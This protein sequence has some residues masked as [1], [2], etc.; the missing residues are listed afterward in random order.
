MVAIFVI[1]LYHELQ[2]VFIYRNKC[3]SEFFCLFSF[4]DLPQLCTNTCTES[5]DFEL[6]DIC[7]ALPCEC[8]HVM[9]CNKQ[10]QGEQVPCT[11][12]VKQ[13]VIHNLVRYMRERKELNP[14]KYLM[15]KKQNNHRS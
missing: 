10:L 11:R 13:L 5:I 9:I 15:V 1:W 7:F 2:N 14:K 4:L 8:L 6:C 3:S 12:H